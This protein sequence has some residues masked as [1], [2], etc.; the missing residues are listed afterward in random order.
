[1]NQRLRGLAGLALLVL[2]LSGA[3]ATAQVVYGGGYNPWTGRY[4]GGAAGY[5]PY[6]GRVVSR[7]GAYNPWTGG[8]SGGRQWYNPYT[9][10]SGG[11]RSYYN[12]WTGRSGAGVY[13]RRW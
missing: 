13:R 9:G 1:M 3:K 11:S 6:T 4:G 7:G 10:R 5:N 2:A 12:P 8:Y